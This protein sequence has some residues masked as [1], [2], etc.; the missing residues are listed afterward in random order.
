MKRLWIVACAAALAAS[1]A[2]HAYDFDIAMK[3]H[4]RGM[5]T[6]NSCEVAFARDIPPKDV[7]ARLARTAMDLCIAADRSQD[8]E[9]NVF[10]GDELIDDGLFHGYWVFNHKTGRIEHH[11]PGEWGGK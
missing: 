4:Q 7:I 1:P 9:L 6:L 10:K 3:T 2:A 5:E 11:E 8:I